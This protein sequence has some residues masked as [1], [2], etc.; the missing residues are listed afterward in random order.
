MFQALASPDI[1]SYLSQWLKKKEITAL[2]NCSLEFSFISQRCRFSEQH[3]VNAAKFCKSIMKYE[4]SYRKLCKSVEKAK[5]DSLLFSL[6][7]Y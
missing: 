6:K 7:A 3:R 5:P 4:S 2:S 1:I